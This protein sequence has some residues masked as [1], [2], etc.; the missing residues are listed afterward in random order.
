[1]KIL[2]FSNIWIRTKFN[3]VTLQT[4]SEVHGVELGPSNN[5]VWIIR[6]GRSP[7][8]SWSN[9]DLNYCN[10]LVASYQTPSPRSKL[11]NRISSFPSRVCLR[12]A[13][14]QWAELLILNNILQDWRAHIDCT[15]LCESAPEFLSWQKMTPNPGI[16]WHRMTEL[17]LLHITPK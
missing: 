8:M 1:M 14:H 15:C 7:S 2:L 16:T 12:C 17:R 11:C 6:W 3:R 5:F 10:T 4:N 9:V 13:P